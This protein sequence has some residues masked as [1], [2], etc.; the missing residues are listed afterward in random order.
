MK[1]VTHTNRNDFSSIHTRIDNMLGDVWGKNPASMR[2][3][4][5]TAP[6]SS[7]YAR[8][9]ERQPDAPRLWNE[10]LAFAADG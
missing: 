7:T 3:S 9:S 10:T 2:P 5:K 1:T 8:Q 4:R 6:L